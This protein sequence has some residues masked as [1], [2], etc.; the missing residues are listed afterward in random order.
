MFFP[1]CPCSANA[2][3]CIIILCLFV[4]VSITADRLNVHSQNCHNPWTASL[5]LLKSGEAKAVLVLWG[6]PGCIIVHS[7]GTPGWGCH[8]N[9]NHGDVL[10]I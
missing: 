6:V 5:A 8:T 2:C 3:N 1:C 7:S 10:P 9:I 4:V